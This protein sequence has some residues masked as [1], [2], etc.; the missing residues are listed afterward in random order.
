MQNSA[1]KHRVE[2][3]VRE[4]Q[5]LPGTLHNQSTR[6]VIRVNGPVNQRS[7]R[8]DAMHRH[9]RPLLQEILHASSSSASDIQNTRYPQN[10]KES[11]DMLQSNVM[12]I[13]IAHVDRVVR[14]RRALVVFPLNRL[15]CPHRAAPSMAISDL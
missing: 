5:G 2:A 11:P 14:M 9:S 1:L 7:N 6:H 15:R 8:L 3:P 10:I 12:F 13:S 4:R